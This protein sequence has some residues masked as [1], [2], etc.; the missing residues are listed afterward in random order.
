VATAGLA[1]E[2]RDSIPTLAQIADVA[3]VFG[4]LLALGILAMSVG[5]LR[6][7]TASSLRTLTAAGASGT[8]RRAISAATA[9]ALALIGAVVGTAAGY[10][11]AIGFFRT[12][13]LDTLSSLSSIPVTS[14]LLILVGLPLAGVIGG[15]L[16]AGHEPSAIGRRPLE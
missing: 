3:S 16:V 2:T 14:L 10:I 11:A 6:S 15:W 12:N 1:A 13:Q 5:L 7:E 8:A 4:I 9:G